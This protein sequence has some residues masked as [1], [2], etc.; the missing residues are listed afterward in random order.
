MLLL[1]DFSKAF[2]MVNHNILL[3]KLQHY[4]IRGIANKWFKSYLA[5]REQFVSV[6]NKNSRSS[7]LK[8]GVPQG[9]ILGPLLFYNL[10]Q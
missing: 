10:H 8:H 3:D 2:D 7:K 1:I 5:D 4:G 6:D 9:S